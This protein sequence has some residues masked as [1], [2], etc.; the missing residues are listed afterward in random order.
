LNCRTH[1]RV[2]RSSQETKKWFSTMPL[3]RAGGKLTRSHTTLIDAA[4]PL[5]DYL[6]TLEVVSKISLGV[7]KNIGKGPASLK[8]LAVTGGWKVTIR[9]NTS[10]QEIIVYTSDPDLVRHGLL[11][12]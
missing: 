5:V 3:H 10:L 6:Q 9:G 8:F 11:G 2:I 1:F 7:I 12:L 4:A